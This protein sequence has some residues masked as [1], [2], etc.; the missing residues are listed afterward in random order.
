MH[1]IGTA[2]VVVQVT[3][4][5]WP[6]PAYT[7]LVTGL[8]RFKVKELIQNAPYLVAQVMQLDKL[9]GEETGKSLRGIMGGGSEGNLKGTGDEGGRQREREEGR[10]G[11]GGRKERERGEGRPIYLVAQVMQLDKLPGEEKRDHM[12]RRE[13]GMKG[14]KGERI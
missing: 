10:K 1:P 12:G 9:P 2:A 8:C 13:D 11:R 6:K 14:F 3:G 5:N 4:T 7:L